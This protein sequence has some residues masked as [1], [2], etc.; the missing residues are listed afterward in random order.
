MIPESKLIKNEITLRELSLSEEVKLA[1][2]SM[3][4]WLALSLGLVSPK[5]S[6]TLILD[7]LE[8][9]FYAHIKKE[10]LT[11]QEIFNRLEILN[12]EKPNQKAVYYHLLRLK[13]MGFL[14]NREKEY[15]LTDEE[16]SLSQFLKGFYTSK[17]ENSFGNISSIASSL[18]NSL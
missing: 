1:K 11:S 16:L 15:F 6:R 4:R 9:L 3:I 14:K 13:E 12:S 8:I 10:R 18:E 17:L 5:E 2:K 7:I